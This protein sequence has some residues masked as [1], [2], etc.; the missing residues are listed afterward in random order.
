MTGNKYACN[1]RNDWDHISLQSWSP[2]G[3]YL[4]SHSIGNKFSWNH[5][6]FFSS[7]SSKNHSHVT[8]GLFRNCTHIWSLLNEVA[9]CINCKIL[10]AFMIASLLSPFCDQDCDHIWYLPLLWLQVYLVRFIKIIAIIS[11][12][13]LYCS[14][15]T[16]PFASPDQYDG[17][18]KSYEFFLTL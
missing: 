6:E 16:E 2:K 15:T 12:P 11:G 18:E 9:T 17:Y 13:A 1:E 8:L 3:I 14:V 7:D 5:W 4:Q 10:I